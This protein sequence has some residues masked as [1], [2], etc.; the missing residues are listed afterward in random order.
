[1]AAFVLSQCDAVSVTC[2]ILGG[3]LTPLGKNRFLHVVFEEVVLDPKLSG[4]H[5]SGLQSILKA[6]LVEAVC[7]GVW[8]ELWPESIECYKY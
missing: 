1:M 5:D 7:A 4:E 6:R 3:T 2:M 8:P